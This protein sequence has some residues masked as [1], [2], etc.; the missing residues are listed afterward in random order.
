MQIVQNLI[1][2]V[3]ENPVG[4]VAA[5]LIVSSILFAVL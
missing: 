3:R 5:I 4:T 1:K 2:F